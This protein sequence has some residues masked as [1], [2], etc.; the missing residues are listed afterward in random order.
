MLKATTMVGF[1][2]ILGRDLN[3]CVP[4]KL[5][6]ATTMELIEPNLYHPYKIRV[7]TNINK[8]ERKSGKTRNTQCESFFKEASK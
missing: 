7:L 4:L 5:E 2:L 3:L 6:V 1:F 8:R